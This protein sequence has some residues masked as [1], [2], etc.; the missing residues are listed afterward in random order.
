[1]RVIIQ[2]A[3]HQFWNSVFCVSCCVVKGCLLPP[4]WVISLEM[5]PFQETRELSWVFFVFTKVI[6]HLCMFHVNVMRKCHRAEGGISNFWMTQLN[7]SSNLKEIFSSLSSRYAGV[8][9]CKNRT[10][11]MFVHYHG[12]LAFSSGLG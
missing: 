5:E 1:M 10:K 4:Q 3:G 11:L 8:K 7:R 12:K 2:C 9:K 6:V